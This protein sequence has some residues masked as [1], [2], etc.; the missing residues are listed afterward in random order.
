[1]SSVIEYIEKPYELLNTLLSQLKVD[2]ILIDRTPFIDGNDKIVI[3]TVPT[4][5]YKASY[6]CH[7]FNLTKFKTFFTSNGYTLF[8]EFEALDGKR[9]EISFRG[10]IYIRNNVF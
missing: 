2:Y 6:P 7:L 5:I 10:M 1:M 3:Q 4:N 8:E 9:K